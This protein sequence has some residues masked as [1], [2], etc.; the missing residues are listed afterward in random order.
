MMRKTVTPS[1]PWSSHS[2]S[3]RQLRGLGI[4]ARGG[5]VSAAE[6]KDA[7]NVCSQSSDQSYKVQK[8]RDDKWA[9]DCPDFLKSTKTCKHVF[10]VQYWLRLPSIASRNG[11]MILEKGMTKNGSCK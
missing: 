6:Q 1:Q 10:A 11:Y 5:Q 2:F 3:K 9:C 7:Y 4:V 8:N